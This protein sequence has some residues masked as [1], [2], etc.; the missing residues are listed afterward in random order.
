M[1]QGNEKLLEAVLPQTSNL[2]FLTVEI[3]LAPLAIDRVFKAA[4]GED[5]RGKEASC[6]NVNHS[7]GKC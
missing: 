6:P 1:V 7:A 4:C 5:S 3:L 2:T